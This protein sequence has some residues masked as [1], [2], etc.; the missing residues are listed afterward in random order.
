MHLKLYA[1]FRVSTPQEWVAH[2]EL[3]RPEKRNALQEEDYISILATE[4]MGRG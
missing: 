4:G 1:F 2:V 3:N